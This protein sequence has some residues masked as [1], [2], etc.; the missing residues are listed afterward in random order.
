MI[1]IIK[2]GGFLEQMTTVP[3]SLSD[4]MAKGTLM[5]PQEFEAVLRQVAAENYHD[6]HPFHKMLHGGLLSKHQVQA[7]AINRYCFQAAAPRKDAILISRAL[8]RE[9]RREWVL[10]LLDHDGFGSDEGGIERWLKLTDGLSL[11]RH[12][13]T[14]MKGALPATVVTIESYLSFVREQPFVAAVATTLTE[15]FAPKLHRK[16]LSAMLE[17]YDFID[18]EVLTYFKQRLTHA[19]RDASFALEYVIKN[20]TSPHDQQ[21]CIEAVKFKCKMLWELLDAL[22]QAYV[23]EQCPVGAFRPENATQEEAVQN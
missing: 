1:H 17:S 4:R 21:A 5:V 9:F 12:Y 8:D 2:L 18:H 23:L 3:K 11:D 16:R 15:L 22:H 14:S 6:K 19:P 20:A 7:W 10:R 13:V